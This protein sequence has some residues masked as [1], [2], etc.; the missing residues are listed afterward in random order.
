MTK[1]KKEARWTLK[2]ILEEKDFEKILE[3]T[4]KKSL[5]FKKELENL[6]P[7]MTG[8]DFKKLMKKYERLLE[9]TLRVQNFAF[10]KWAV[11]MSSDK[12]MYYQGRAKELIVP[13]SDIKLILTRWLSGLKVKGIKKLDKKNR[14]R[15][16]RSMPELSFMFERLIDSKK[17][18]LSMPEEKVITR[19]DSNLKTPLLLLYGMITDGFTFE[20][21]TKRMKKTKTIKTRAELTHYIRSKKAEERKAAY[22]AMFKPFKENISKLFTI[23]QAVVRDWDDSASSRNYPSPISLRN[24][25]NSVDDKT[26]ET[27]MNVCSDNVKLFQE[28]FKLKAKALKLKKLSRY[29]IYAPVGKG[30]VKKYTYSQGKK[31]VLT[32]LKNFTPGFHSR[33]KLIFDSNHVDSHPRQGKRSGAFCSTVSPSVTPHVLLNFIGNPSS[34]MTMAHEI[35]HGIHSLYSNKQSL[36]VS[37][38]PLPLAET[39]STFSEMLM[40]DH[41]LEKIKD[42][43]AKR[44]L[45]FEKLASSYATIIRQNYFVKFEIAAHEHIQKGATAEQLN[46]LYYANLKEQFGTSIKIPKEFKHEWSYIPHIF[47]TPFYCYAYNFGELLAMSLYSM[48]KERGDSFIPKI[49]KILA[50]GGSEKPSRLLRKFDI[51]INSSEFWKKSFTLVKEWIDMIENL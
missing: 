41:L 6:D 23:Y 3:R 16:F 2:N 17:H 15:L 24:W 38:S 10:L 26:I 44:K 25:S 8:K 42:K 33:A 46:E 12:S 18:S 39:A 32:V 36:L 50:S 29:D 37:S 48:Y 51:D 40:F 27:L 22:Q 47:R 19:K 28:Y 13:A 20:Y 43:E 35:G 4:K 34:V 11:D 21:K 7:G 49:E 30:K 1:S 14:E 5:R 45:L 31:E 9:D